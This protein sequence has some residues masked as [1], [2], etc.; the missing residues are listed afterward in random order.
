MSDFKNIS[1]HQG[2]AV[3]SWDIECRHSLSSLVRVSNNLA[4]S[5]VRRVVAGMSDLDH[6]QV[7]SCLHLSAFVSFIG[8]KYK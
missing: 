3:D 8:N 2:S 5:G 4:K 7:L 1:K 6:A